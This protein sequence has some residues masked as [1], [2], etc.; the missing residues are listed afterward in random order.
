MI[1]IKDYILCKHKWEDEMSKGLYEDGTN[2]FYRCKKCGAIRYNDIWDEDREH[3][4]YVINLDNSLDDSEED[5]KTAALKS[6]LILLL[7]CVIVSIIR[8]IIGV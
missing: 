1:R 8:I 4:E 2:Y 7:I 6:L 3:I 5:N